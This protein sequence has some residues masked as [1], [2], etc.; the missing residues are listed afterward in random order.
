MESQLRFISS[1]NRQDLVEQL[2]QQVEKCDEQIT[3]LETEAEEAKQRADECAE[4]VKQAQEQKKRCEQEFDATETRAKESQNH[5]AKALKDKSQAKKDQAVIE[6]EL[7]KLVLKREEVIRQS[8]LDGVDLPKT[9]EDDEYDFSLLKNSKRKSEHEFIAKIQELKEEAAG[10]TPNA[11]AE[12]RLLECTER[13][14]DCD[15]NLSQSREETKLADEAFEKVRSARHDAFTRMFSHVSLKIDSVYKE[16]TKRQ[17]APLGGSAFLA[18][19]DEEGA[20]TGGIKF[21][22]MPPNKRYRAMEQLSGGEKTIAALALLFA[23]HTYRPSPF[24]VLD[25]V[26]AALDN[27]NVERVSNYIRMRSN[28]N[29]N[30]DESFR[31]FQC[32]VI[33]LKDGFFSKSES[34]VGVYREV[35]ENSSRALT[36]NLSEY[37]D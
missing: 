29:A 16:L 4:Q 32:L 22:C 36:L 18:L 6:D 14:K 7:Q 21:E 31:P 5:L 13:V 24:F 37:A 17:N 34:L 15:T 30:E 12:A 27:D 3:K 20:F 11:R 2:E 9:D 1:K 8:A 25:E 19:E 28:R 23:I 26:D 10:L 33:S 35:E